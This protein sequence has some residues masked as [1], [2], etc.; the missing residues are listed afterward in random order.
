MELF[1][2]VRAEEPAAAIKQVSR[3]NRAEFVAGGTTILDL[4]KLNVQSPTQLV[5][6]NH[7]G[8]A[9]IDVTDAG[10]RIGSMVRNSDVAYH[11]TIRKRYPVLCEALLAGATAQVRNMASVGGNLLQRTRCQ[12]FRDTAWPCNKREPGSGC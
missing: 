2:Y 11:E 3:D 8:L 5:D 4:M 10:V 9:R 7:L 1:S 12:Y 6:V